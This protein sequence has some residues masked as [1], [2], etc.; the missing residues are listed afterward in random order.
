MY[1]MMCAAALALA[2]TTAA[3]HSGTA[4]FVLDGNR[5]Y[6]ELAFVRPDGSE[7][8]ALAFVDMGSPAVALRESLFKDLKLDQGQPLVFTIGGFRI[9]VPAA[10]V[11]SEPRAPSS[12]GVEL[13]VEGILPARVLKN[14]QVVI[15]YRQRML[16]VARPQ[17]VSL[18]GIAVPFRM[19]ETTGLLS[20]EASIDGTSYPITIDNGSAY[21]WVRQNVGR[22]WLAAH[23]EWERGVGAVGPSNM[24]MSGT[25]IETAGT[26]LR[27]PR[28]M[29]GP[30]VLS[31]VG[32]LAV[33]PGT[34]ENLDLFDW[35]SQKNAGSVD[36]WIGG[37][38]LKAYRI[39]IDYPKRVMYWQKQGDPDMRDL[40]QVGLTLASDGGE[41]LVAAVALKNGRP[42]VEG[43]LPG[44]RLMRI[45]TLDTAGATWGAIYGALH[46]RPGEGRVLMIERDGRRLSVPAIVIAF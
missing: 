11:V 27:I 14:Y 6:A 31:E 2:G 7:H 13:K 4:P 3:P 25:Q 22:T 42:T 32:A 18:R 35:Y 36:G 21:T 19:N 12:L 5:M 17:T 26:L 28:V 24:M 29:A 15:D 43:V 16:T 9:Q 33:G 39:T 40:D 20:I 30:L 23:P 37:N 46:G 38:V 8:R 10:D 41:F 1:R 34:I 44:D 45:D